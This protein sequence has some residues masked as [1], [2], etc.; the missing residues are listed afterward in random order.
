MPFHVFFE[1]FRLDSKYFYSNF[2]YFFSKGLKLS[3]CDFC[4]SPALIVGSFFLLKSHRNLFFTG[5][6]FCKPGAIQ[7]FKLNFN[8]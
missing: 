8:L 6:D 5:I 2:V 4:R 3:F 7:G 1:L